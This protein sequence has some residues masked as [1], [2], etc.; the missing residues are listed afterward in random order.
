VHGVKPN[1]EEKRKRSIS[2]DEFGSVLDKG[3]LPVMI[4]PK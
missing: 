1:K 4:G 3:R 2:D